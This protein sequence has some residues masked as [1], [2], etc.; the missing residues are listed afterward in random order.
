[1]SDINEEFVGLVPAAGY[2]N[3]ISPIPCSKEIFPIGFTSLINNSGLSPKAVSSY[4]LEGMKCAGVKQVLFV[5]RKGKWDIPSYYLTGDYLDLDLA[6]V[7]VEETDGAP[8]TIEKAFPFCVEKNIVFGF[9][10]IVFQPEDALKVMVE[11][12]NQS[13]ADIVLGLF[14]ANNPEKVDMIEFSDSGNVKK[15]IIKPD[16]TDLIYT[17][18]LAVWTSS[19]TKFIQEYLS[20]HEGDLLY[21]K[22]SDIGKK[23]DEIYIGNIIQKAIE[24]GLNVESVKFTD[25]SYIDIGTMEDLKKAMKLYLDN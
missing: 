19:F 4:L 20:G 7:V 11:K 3:R 15:I 9:P 5:I 23:N 8:F 25:G 1:M 17:W 21:N 10:D 22:N 18:L 6:Y 16:K 13:H 14:K 12:K 2:A 24:A